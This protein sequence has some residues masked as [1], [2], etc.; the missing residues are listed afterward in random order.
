[1][2][3][4]KRE[5]FQHMCV[6][7]QVPSYQGSP[8]ESSLLPGNG[9]G[10]P[11]PTRS[12]SDHSLRSTYTTTTGGDRQPLAEPV[13]LKSV[14]VVNT[15]WASQVSLIDGFQMSV[16]YVSYFWRVSASLSGPWIYLAAALRSQIY[17]F[18]FFPP[19]LFS[20]PFP[21]LSSGE[22]WVQYNDGAQIKLQP[23]GSAAVMYIS[24]QGQQS[25]H[26]VQIYTGNTFIAISMYHR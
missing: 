5:W 12:R 20:F 19:P 3:E 7:L 25:R 6:C 2:P 18:A 15:G 22:V 24:P 1:M 4:W 16:T 13:V 26:V 8:H 10:H 21:Q 14:Y 9:R 23:S 11:R 17:Q